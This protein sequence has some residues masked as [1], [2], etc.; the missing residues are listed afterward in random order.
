[1]ETRKKRILRA[2]MLP[3][4]LLFSYPLSILLKLNSQYKFKIKENSRHRK[5][6]AV[7]IGWRNFSLQRHCGRYLR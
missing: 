6:P 4:L 1:M 3:K 2:L 5:M 7:G